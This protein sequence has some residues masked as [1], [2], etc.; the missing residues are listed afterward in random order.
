VFRGRAIEVSGRA[1]GVGS[2]EGVE[3]LRLEVVLAGDRELLL[4]VTVSREHG[5]YR[6]TFGV[7]PDLPVGDYRLLVRTPGNDAYRPARAD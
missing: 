3:G 6:G 1:T 4:G 2:G 7:P 5:Y